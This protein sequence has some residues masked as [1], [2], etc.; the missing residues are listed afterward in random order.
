MTRPPDLSPVFVTQKVSVNYCPHAL[1]ILGTLT[2][3]VSGGTAAATDLDSS[4]RRN[5]P[6]IL[7]IAIDDLNAA[8]KS[9]LMAH[10]P[11]HDAPQPKESS[12]SASKTKNAKKRAAQ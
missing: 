3:L 11:R 6:N 9:E 2:I 12:K 7:F 5:R 1:V 8:L 10:L 4:F